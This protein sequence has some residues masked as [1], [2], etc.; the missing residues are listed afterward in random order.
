MSELDLASLTPLTGGW[1]GQ[2]FLADV[3]GERSV[4]RIYANPGHRGDAAHEVD[5]ALLELVR[6][7]L[8]VPDV[9]EV[10]RADPATGAPALLITS[11][12]E[13]V[14]GD[15][16]L[17]TLDD[18]G[19][20]HLGRRLGEVLA[21]LGGIPMLRSGPFVDGDLRI[22]S[23]GDVDDLPAHV[24]STQLPWFSPDDRA[25]LMKVAA[26]AQERLDGVGRHCLVHSDFNP[27]NLVL[28]PDTLH[29]RAVL[30]W[31][32]S[33]AGSPY[34]D[35]GNLLRFDRQPAFAEAVLTAYAPRFWE[36]PRSTLELAR[37]ADLWALVELAGRKGQNPV[38]DRAHAHLVQIG[39]TGALDAIPDAPQR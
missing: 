23:F 1:S 32:F 28:D 18:D 5:A 22:G 8:P 35:L 29:V 16:L 14:R 36:D 26:K 9:L 37:A 2:T 24:A 4:V 11:Y 31:E 7:L 13:G 39:R 20:A 17:P 19:L 27:K 6:G 33:H 38:A 30:D 21:V 10:R 25:G 3:A 12:V 34:T 15:E